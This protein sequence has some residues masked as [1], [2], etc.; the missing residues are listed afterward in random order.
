MFTYCLNNPACFLDPA[1]TCSYKF[2]LGGWVDCGK[3]NCTSS[4]NYLPITVSMGISGSIGIGPLVV[5]FQFAVVTDSTGYS[6][7]QFTSYMPYSPGQIAGSP[8]TDEMLELAG[9]ADK[10]TDYMQLSLMG[11][12]SFYNTPRAADLYG[13][14]YQYGKTIGLGGAAGVDINIIPNQDGD[15]Y[16][17]I[18]FSGGCGSGDVHCAVSDTMSVTPVPFSVYD[19]AEAM[20][21]GFYGVD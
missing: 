8:S 10:A 14:G 12:M 6:E 15:P 18:T 7:L 9:T 13:A 3:S 20:I 2:S 19:L 11:N 1:G 16:Q 21:N 17:G 5:G 4:S